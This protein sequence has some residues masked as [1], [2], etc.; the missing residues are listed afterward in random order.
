MTPTEI[1]AVKQSFA[2]V[3]PIADQAGAMFYAKL[4]EL[5]PSVRPMFAADM[6]PQGKKL[7]QVLAVAV[8]GLDKL[9][10][11]VPT[12]QALGVRHIAYGVTPAHY[13]TVAA[14]LLWTLAQGLGPSWTP[15]LEAAWVKTYVLVA[16]TMKAAA[17][18]AATAQATPAPPTTH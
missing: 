13:D 11:I 17:A 6:G 8:N 9:D 7:L 4:F 14:A 18:Q 2:K 15:D 10:T 1:A 12:V 16:G 5:D 3:L